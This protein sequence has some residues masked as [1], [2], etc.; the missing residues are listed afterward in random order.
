[1]TSEVVGCKLAL[2]RMH[3]TQMAPVA[4]IA[5]RCLNRLVSAVA[6]L[7]CADV[8]SPS[9][10]PPA[11]GA[12]I[13][14]QVSGLRAFGH[15]SISHDRVFVTTTDHRVFAFDLGSGAVVWS[16][17]LPSTRPSFFGEGCI[18]SDGVVVVG[19]EDVFA[20]EASSGN[21]RWRFSPAIGRNP[22]LFL[23]AVDAGGIVAGSSSGHVYALDLVSGQEVWRTHIVPAETVSVFRP[24]LSN[25]A[26]YVAFTAFNHS[27]SGMDRGGV[28]SLDRQS[29]SVRW[30]KFLPVS[31][32]A[33]RVTATIEPALSGDVVL[34][35]A[36]DGPVYAFAAADGSPLWSLPPVSGDS[37]SPPVVPDYRPLAGATDRFIVGTTGRTLLSVQASSGR[38][39]WTFRQSFGSTGW[40]SV[41]GDDV[42]IVYG[43][44]QLEVLDGRTG[45]V[46][47]R[48]DRQSASFSPAV[49]DST[50]IA[51]GDGVTAYRRR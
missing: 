24:V 29:G 41:H 6:L 16:T 28:A 12:S 10:Q 19:D 9:V 1:M 49:G 45:S 4:G 30:L 37:G 27:G 31:A 26:V 32:P 13:R 23:P 14:W 46:R 39:E 25:S 15:P 8:P 38:P 51:A 47:W 2:P 11:D 50:V 40:I 21:V 18:Y 44:G 20:L 3:K 43:G 17:R 5:R 33:L 22:G 7:A 42:F 36:R 48:S 35:G 34:A